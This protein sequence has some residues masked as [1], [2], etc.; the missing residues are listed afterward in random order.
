MILIIIS[1][2]KGEIEQ[3]NTSNMIM[4]DWNTV[5]EIALTQCTLWYQ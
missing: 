1:D 4:L 3:S 5:Y 2:N